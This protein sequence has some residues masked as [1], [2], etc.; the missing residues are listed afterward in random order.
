MEAY[1][2][3]SAEG[4]VVGCEALRWWRQ[5]RLGHL[6]S[7]ELVVLTAEHVGYHMLDSSSSALNEAKVSGCCRVPRF[8]LKGTRCG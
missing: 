6:S 2:C 1:L 5:W 7:R 3:T 8:N 4:D